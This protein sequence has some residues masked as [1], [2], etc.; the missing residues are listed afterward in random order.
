MQKN[1]PPFL[2]PAVRLFGAAA[3]CFVAQAAWAQ[4]VSRPALSPIASAAPPAALGCLI[5]PSSTVE[6]GAST[7]SV[8][9]SLMAERGDLVRKG[10]AL[11]RLDARV[12]RASARVARTRAESIADLEAASQQ[13]DLARRRADRAAELAKLDFVSAQA[14][15]QAETEAVAARLRLQQAR[16][17]Q[18]LAARE[19]DV[20]RAQ[21]AQR[22][23]V[24]PMTGVV[25]ERYVT[26][27]ERV[28][29][30][31]LFKL[32]QIDP[33]RVD[34]VLAASQFG[35]LQPGAAVSVSPELPG[36][37]PRQATVALVDRVID[38]ASGTFRVRLSLPNPDQSLPAGLRC[39]VDLGQ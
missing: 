36:A 38:A 20:A 19:L 8:V 10:Q 16:E 22:T 9:E 30:K 2:N 24:S 12:E 15:E 1:D 23:I 34:L 18:A 31:P 39:R 3:V 14:V 21:V 5:E 32:A 27:G 7:F 25:V 29:N 11:A 13:H 35:R 26:A 6:V 17:Q 4:A 28:E 33:L 37:A